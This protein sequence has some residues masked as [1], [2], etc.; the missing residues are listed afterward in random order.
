[1]RNMAAE[2]AV[3]VDEA[4]ERARALWS[5]GRIAIVEAATGTMRSEVAVKDGGEHDEWNP[6]PPTAE[7]KNY[8]STSWGYVEMEYLTLKLPPPSKPERGAA[9]LKRLLLDFF[10]ERGEEE[11]FKFSDGAA[12]F[13]SLVGFCSK[14]YGQYSTRGLRAVVHDSGGDYPSIRVELAWLG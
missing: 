6:T 8:I 7:F 5:Q 3:N 13:E 4:V 12:V 11:E 1:M 14:A 9:A 10:A 2:G